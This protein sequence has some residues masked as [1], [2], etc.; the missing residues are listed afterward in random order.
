MSLFADTMEWFS[1]GAP[2]ARRLLEHLGLSALVLLI[3][4][5]IAVPIG[6]WVGH[7]RRGEA[8]VAAVGNLG[9][10]LPTL[11]LVTLLGLG[12]GIGLKAPVVAL[13]IL[14]IPPLL[15][16]SYSAISSVDP[17]VVRSAY[18]Q[19]MTTRQVLSRVE[20]PLG[21]PVFFGAL[22]TAV[23]QVVATATLAAYVADVGLGRFILHGLKASDYGEMIGGSLVVIALALI[24]E[25]L[26]EISAVF[27]GRKK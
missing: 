11:G 18:S 20:I 17:L 8:A 24:L 16:G 4:A 7:A 2:I 15:A 22:R 1:S 13:V 10:S 5:I 14:A 6:L 23:I 21:W 12:L 9:R 25:V 19:G 27:T 26:F 3:A